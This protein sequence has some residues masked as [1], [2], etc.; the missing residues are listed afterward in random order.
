MRWCLLAT[1]FCSVVVCTAT[2][3]APPRTSYERAMRAYQALEFA[4]AVDLF[5]QDL[6]VGDPHELE[7]RQRIVLSLYQL[8]RRDEAV[9]DYHALLSRFPTFRFDD[10]EVLPETIAFFDNRKPKL[11]KA[12]PEQPRRIETVIATS[13]PT[14]NKPWH[15]YTLAP[16]GI[17]QFV[18][19]SPIRKNIFT[20]LQAGL[21]AA[22]VALFVVHNRQVN[23]LRQ[24]NDVGNAYVVQN[25]MNV[26]F[27][28]M[29]GSLA[30][31]LVDGIFFEP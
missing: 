14:P 20:I 4:Q 6:R 13:Q 7:V 27:F 12:A 15:W 9:L 26:V 25:T 1:L 24:A 31:G 3:A 17:G 8:G 11:I 30:A 29:L 23:G 22:D 21:I 2:E 5:K 28:A 16:L 10:N 18:A 19:G